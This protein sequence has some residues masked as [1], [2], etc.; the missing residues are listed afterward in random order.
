M[1]QMARPLYGTSE[2][3]HVEF[4]FDC[5]ISWEKDGEPER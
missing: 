5:G 1:A 4:K 2:K 3:C